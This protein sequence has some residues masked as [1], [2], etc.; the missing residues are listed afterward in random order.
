M[1]VRSWFPGLLGAH[2]VIAA[3][4]PIGCAPS[5]RPEPPWF[6]LTTPAGLKNPDALAAA[7][8]PA[9]SPPKP[10]V[11]AGEERHTDLEGA[12]IKASLEAI[13]ALSEESKAQGNRFW[14]RVPGFPSLTKTIEW[15]AQQYRDAGL[16]KVEVQTFESAGALM[17]PRSW[18]VRLLADP[19]FGDGSADVILASAFPLRDADVPGG[20]LTAPLAYVGEPPTEKTP[21][22][23]DVKGKVAVQHVKPAG[24]VLPDRDRIE[25]GSKLLIGQGAVAVLNIV[26]Q[27][28]N[29]HVRD[30][31]GCVGACFNV[32]GDD[33][34]FLKSVIE[35]ASA[36]NT[37]LQARI[38]MERERIAS[39][40]AENAVGVVPGASSEIVIVNA[41]ADGHFNASGDN[42]DG[43]AVQMALAR[44]FAKKENRP[45][46]TLVFVSS[47]GHH[48][49]G[50]PAPGP[51]GPANFV[52]M[53]PE[54][55][56]KA[57]IVLNLEHVSQLEIETN[58]WKVQPREQV[59][60]FGVSNSAPFMI[61]LVKRGID[62]YGFRLNPQVGTGVGGDLGG[63]G[64]TGLPRAQAIRVGPLYHTSGDVIETVSV[65]G[66]E[67]A[68]RFWAFLIAE[69]AKAPRAKL[70]PKH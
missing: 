10:V 35:R 24:A 11:P 1:R 27:D 30:Y 42:A 25:T 51:N 17:W 15:S 37:P 48:G 44:H 63:Y 31:S 36:A 20:T 65:P 57:V 61:D 67:R 43:L 22:S 59:M 19:A 14:G 12:T 21:P 40:R 23:A 28:G 39:P 41:H 9:F 38:T 7:K 6:G 69:V 53:N 50:L 33:G 26:E 54:I 2:L 4:I 46:R 34:R 8:D 60:N 56:R 49:F 47:S 52:R 13:V 32:G 58:P 16:T 55:I 66:L 3:L 68:A 45:A 62:R 70:D 18:E 5:S 64:P 29:M